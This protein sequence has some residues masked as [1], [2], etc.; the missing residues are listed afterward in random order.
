MENTLINRDILY[1]S[2]QA[3]L[4][5]EPKHGDIV[6]FQ[7]ELVDS[8]SGQKK[9]LV[10]RVVGLP[11][12]RLS[13]RGGEVFLNGS[14]LAEPYVKS[15]STAGLMSEITVPEGCYFV[16]GDNREVSNDSR[17]P[18]VGSQQLVTSSG[19]VS[20]VAKDQLRGKVILRIFPMDKIGFL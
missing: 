16:L 1:I 4:F 8:G 3:Y 19:T 18:D 14:A 9:T 6:V 17:Y 20:L 12:D 13:I 7:T 15:G 2:R 11:G 10:K 5:D